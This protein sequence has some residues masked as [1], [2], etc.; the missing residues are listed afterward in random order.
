MVGFIGLL[1]YLWW[2]YSNT[3]THN[4]EKCS[5]RR[6]TLPVTYSFARMQ[7]STMSYQL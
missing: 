1:G 6:D 4:H 3:N 5:K 7:H 2:W